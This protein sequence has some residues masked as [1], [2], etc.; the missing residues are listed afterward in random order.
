MGTHVETE[1]HQETAA[2]TS[3]RGSLDRSEPGEV[4]LKGQTIPSH[5]EGMVPTWQV[6]KEKHRRGR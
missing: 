1:A 3:N 5:V 6:R 4:M 2:I